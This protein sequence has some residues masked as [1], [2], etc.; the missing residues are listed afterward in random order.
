MRQQQLKRV[1]R[2]DQ[3]ASSSEEAETSKSK[4]GKRKK[5]KSRNMRRN[6]K[7]L[8]NE[9]NLEA[10]TKEAQVRDGPNSAFKSFLF[11]LARF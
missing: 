1:K 11:I 8:L 2:D 6:I 7:E 4:H 5:K 3:E 10:T 9:K